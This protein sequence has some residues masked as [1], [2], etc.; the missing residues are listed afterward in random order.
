MRLIGQRCKRSDVRSWLILI[1]RGLNQKKVVQEE[2]EITVQFWVLREEGTRRDLVAIAWWKHLYPSRT[3]KL[4][5]IT[6]T[7]VSNRDNSK[8]PVHF[9]YPHWI[10]FFCLSFISYF[11][12]ILNNKKTCIFAGFMFYLFFNNEAAASS[13][14]NIQSG[15]SWSAL[16]GKSIVLG[17]SAIP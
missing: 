3:Q 6:A 4:S 16:A 12:F 13:A 1:G 10:S 17:A 14:I 11:V 9:G 8:L 2:G 15:W 5:I 7:I